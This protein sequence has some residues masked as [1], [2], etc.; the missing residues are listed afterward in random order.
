MSDRKSELM[1]RLDEHASA[2]SEMDLIN[3]IAERMIKA[4]KTMGST[5]TVLEGDGFKIT[6]KITPVKK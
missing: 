1:E 4:C 6:I 3:I 2:Y 5:S